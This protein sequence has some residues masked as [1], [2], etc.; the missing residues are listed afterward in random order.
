MKVLFFF[1]VALGSYSLVPNMEQEG[2]AL[3][4][5]VKAYVRVE[6]QNV[7]DTVNIYSS[8]LSLLTLKQLFTE[9]YVITRDSA[10]TLAFDNGMPTK[11]D[12]WLDQKVR[13]SIFLVP[14]DT[15]TLKVDY[16][17]SKGGPKITYEGLTARI[18]QY[19]HDKPEHV[20]F[21]IEA[22]RLF[23]NPF[24]L[25]KPEKSLLFY[26]HKSDSIAAIQ[27]AYVRAKAESYSLPAWFVESEE[28]ESLLFACY[29]QLI[30][31]EY[32]ETFFDIHLTMPEG[33]YS[34][35]KQ[36]DITNPNGLYSLYYYLYLPV[37]ITRTPDS[38]QS[39]KQFL[40]SC[41]VESLDDL[42]ATKAYSTYYLKQSRYVSA[43]ADELLP[44]ALLDPL[45][46]NLFFH[47]L[48]VLDRAERAE[49]F[50]YMKGKLHQSELWPY[51]V[52]NYED[53]SLHLSAG[54][55]APDFYLLSSENE[56]Y[57]T[58]RDFRGKVLLLNF[59]FPGCKP[60][61]SEI[62]HEKRLIKQ[63]AAKPF[64]II[65]ICM[66]ATPGQ[67]Q[68][69]LNKFDLHGVNLLTQGNWERKLKEAYGVDA[70]P[71]YVLVDQEGKVVENGTYTPSD[72][73]LQELIDSTLNK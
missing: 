33:Y 29:H 7:R 18:N 25:D 71:H 38:M 56:K 8:Y 61:I 72:S 20:S 59:W 4:L 73:R 2:P 21:S 57:L 69:A 26:K 6:A 54:K 60:C 30:I 37:M 10:F 53:M 31:A 48:K 12:L 14:G 27:Q 1:L 67:W 28:I 70:F 41:G 40:D 24:H 55:D 47:M 51:F 44:D 19:L 23:N 42:K 52:K 16:Q 22:A 5:G 43:K 35:M 62:P 9:E 65:N 68:A 11:Y 39:N 63:Y 50:D 64:T 49:L 15:L 32:W 66:E 3:Q 46:T 45:L 17:L 34:S 13:I 36:I 58:L